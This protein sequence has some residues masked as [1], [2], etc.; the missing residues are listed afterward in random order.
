MRDYLS[1]IKKVDL[2]IIG[3]GPAGCSAAIAANKERTLIVDTKSFPRD[4]PCSGLLVEES[5]NALKKTGIPESVFGKPE[6]L[7]L[8]HLDLDNNISVLQ[9]RSLGNVNRIKFDHWLLESVPTEV[10]IWNKTNVTKI[11]QGNTIKVRVVKDGEVLTIEAKQVIGADGSISITRR[12]LGFTPVFTY[13]GEQ[14]FIEFDDSLNECIFIYCNKLTDWYSWV[15]PKQTGVVETGS[16][17][18]PN[19]NRDELLQ[20]LRKKTGFNGKV[21]ERKSWRLSQPRVPNDIQLGNSKNIY[22]AGEAAGFISPST[23]EG[24]SFG[25]RS[26]QALGQSL[27]SENPFRTYSDLTTDL[28]QEV[29]NKAKK[30]R[31]LANSKERAVFLRNIDN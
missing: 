13:K 1:M 19:T 15:L 17:L 5:F 11:M 21:I 28:V 12:E 27:N 10:E 30:A 3:A 20:I 2:L 26:G 6:R 16:A 22:L 8:R 4:K 7:H 18:L 14:D 31:I 29:M 23:G 24:I 9:K 25:L